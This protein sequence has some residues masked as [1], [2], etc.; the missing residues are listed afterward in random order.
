MDGANCLKATEPLWGG[1]FLPFSSQKFLVLI[2]STLEGWQME[3]SL[4]PPSGF[5]HKIPGLEIQC[6]NH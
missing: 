1:S 5:E 4:E 3:S 6:L 2:L